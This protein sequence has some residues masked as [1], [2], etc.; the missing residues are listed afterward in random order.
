MSQRAALYTVRVHPKSKPSRAQPLGDVDGAGT[1]L[2]AVLEQMLTGFVE[3][4][5]DGTR[6]VRALA[7]ATDGDDLFASLQHG[8]SGVAAEI[9]DPSGALR[10]H[11]SPTDVQLVRCGCVFRLPPGALSGWLAVHINDG[12]GLKGLF[13]EGLARRFRARFPGLVLEL[14][15][16]VEATM[17]KDAVD[18][19][20]IEKVKLVKLMQPGEP[21]IAAADKWLSPGQ[22]ARVELDLATVGA[23]ARLQSG[24]V[25]R[26]LGGDEAAFADIV[27]FQGMTFDGAKVEVLLPDDTRRT[28][29][30]RSPQAGRPVT[31]DLP[32]LEFD[33]DGEPTDQ[34]L[35]AELRAAF[36]AAV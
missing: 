21:G 19:N 29:D 24:L 22:P 30:L 1:A 9:D 7:T 5:E 15:Q 27:E 36:P 33:D 14:D 18:Q 34:S 25:K 6:M 2:L 3:V 26:F 11:Q 13:E 12:H 20:R 8:E 4:S 16:F 32:G 31:R 28:F 17:L 23:G 35:F 10:L